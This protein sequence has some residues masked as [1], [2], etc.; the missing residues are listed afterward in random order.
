LYEQHNAVGNWQKHYKVFSK[1]NSCLLTTFFQCGLLQH[2]TLV[3]LVQTDTCYTLA[4][5][6]CSITRNRL[7]GC[8]VIAVNGK[9]TALKVLSANKT[10]QEL[11]HEQTLVSHRPNVKLSS[12]FIFFHNS[13]KL[14][15]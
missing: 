4:Q 10:A 6:A 14:K 11:S 1:C 12:S 8:H 5:A 2:K 15:K 13:R 9:L 7:R 3:A